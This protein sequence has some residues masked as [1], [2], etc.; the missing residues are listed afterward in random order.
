MKAMMDLFMAQPFG[1]RSLMQRLITAGIQDE[2]AGFGKDIKECES[3]I[4]DEAIKTKIK[5]Y[6]YLSPNRQNDASEGE[7]EDVDRV[8]ILRR[9]LSDK[10]VEPLISPETSDLVLGN[11]ILLK[12][13]WKLLLLHTRKLD[14]EEM[15]NLVFEGVTG[16]LLRDIITIFYTPLSQVYASANVGDLVGDVKVFLDDLVGVCEGREVGGG[17]N[18][19]AT[20]QQPTMPFKTFTALVDRH[21]Q[22]LYRFIH[23]VYAYSAPPTSLP[24]PQPQSLLETPTQQLKHQI[25]TSPNLFHALIIYL[26]SVLSFLNS[27]LPHIN[28]FTFL[29]RHLPTELAKREE[30]VQGFWRDVAELEGRAE[31]RRERRRERVRERVAMGSGK[32]EGG[33]VEFF[34]RWIDG[35]DLED[36]NEGGE[37]EGEEE[38]SEESP[39]SLEVGMEEV[40]VGKGGGWEGP[41]DGVLRSRRG[42][43]VGGKFRR[44]D[45]PLLVLPGLVGGFVEHVVSMW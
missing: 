27:S 43:I 26:Q 5:N 37:S 38:E 45:Q 34:G 44:R 10:S 28:L 2:I 8:T 41:G 9:V 19:V 23:G 16:S 32:G 30:W 39:I 36:V 17:K 42:S 13:L 7:E 21:A 24:P 11:K 15:V 25:T 40:D 29:E 14:K 1:G 35:E 18:G 33:G 6:V 3:G 22:N 4:G 20:V 12:A 31:D